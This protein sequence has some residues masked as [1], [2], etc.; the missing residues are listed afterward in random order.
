MSFKY[1]KYIEA[2]Q[3][4]RQTERHSLACQLTLNRQRGM[5]QRRAEQARPLFLSPSLATTM[6]LMTVMSGCAAR[7]RTCSAYKQ[8]NKQTKRANKQMNAR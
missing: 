5:A 8:T 4:E 3:T 2:A 1:L 7:T 6:T